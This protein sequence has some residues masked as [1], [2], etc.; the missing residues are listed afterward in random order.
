MSPVTLNEAYRVLGLSG[1]ATAAEVKA[2]YRR[3]VG[4]A[5]PDRGGSASEFIKVRAAYEI[6]S[7]HLEQPPGEDD[8]PVPEDLRAIIDG[9]VR[10]FREHQRWA[11]TRAAEHLGYFESSLT[12]YVQS[13]GRA[14]LRDLSTRFR[15]SWNAM[16]RALFLECNSRSDAILQ[17]YESWYTESTQAVFD[18]L[19]HKE[20]R[21]FAWRRR[22]WEIFLVL[23]ALAG[24]L[25]VV[26]GWEGPW[27]R[28]VSVGVIAVAL[29]LSFLGYWWWVR[30]GRKN[31]ERVEPLSVVP[32]EIQQGGQFPTE[33]ALR[34][35]RRTT[36][37]LGLGGL[38]LG[39]A[40]AGGFVVPLAGAAVG[41]AL[42][43]AFD[44]LV[45]PTGRMRE[46]MQVDLQR[47]LTMARP[48]VI[49]YVLE[50]HEQLLQDVRGKIV[51]D[52]EERVKGTVKL[53]TAGST[54]ER[55]SSVGEHPVAEG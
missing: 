46:S 30:G 41:A 54:P 52:Y 33:V 43:G 4:E 7:A 40:A 25:T 14:E 39:S 10:E 47:F 42:G 19:Y 23:G 6:L 5:H 29:G 55:S 9:I 1:E 11:E 18:G 36:A 50:A 44:R 53:L 27:R 45:N 34:R 35:G 20:L 15:D 8:V 12:R 21:S 37:A 16:L 17:R 49:A 48:Q 31:R 38:F 28:W 22:F 32:F 3:R 26:I 2:A 51:A 24:A 13:A